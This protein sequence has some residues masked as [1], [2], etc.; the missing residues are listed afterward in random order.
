MSINYD[1]Q[2]IRLSEIIEKSTHNAT[3]LIPDL[4]RPYV[5]SP[6][7]VILLVDSLFRGWPFGSL[8]LWEVAPECYGNNEGIPHRPFWEAVD[9]TDLGNAAVAGQ[10]D[11]PATYYM[12]LDGQQRIQ[13]LLLALGGDN[14]GFCLYDHDWSMSLYERRMRRGRHWSKGTLCVDLEAFQNL[15]KTTRVRK[16]DVQNILEWVR[17]DPE[18][19]TSSYRKPANY[20]TPLKSSYENPGKFI[21]L[22][23]LWDLAQQKLSESEYRDILE[24]FLNNHQLTQEKI[25]DLI[26]PLAEFMAII[27]NVKET[28]FVDCLQI[29]SF[30]ETQQWKKEDYDDAIVNIFTRLNTAGRTLTR[31]E[32]TLAWLKVGW[33]PSLTNNLT[34]GECMNSLKEEI[35]LTGIDL[36]MDDTVRFL[37]LLWAI[38]NRNGVLLDSKDLLKGDIIR[39]MASYIAGNWEV[40]FSGTKT[41]AEFIV[42]RNL[43]ENVGSFNSLFIYWAWSYLSKK[44]LSEH[45]SLRTLEKHSFEV[46]TIKLSE[47]FID[48][49]VI[50]S[51]WA[52]VWAVGAV[53][54]FANYATRLGKTA[55]T[56]KNQNN[57]E[58]ALATLNDTLQFLLGDI[59]KN[60]VSYIETM[61]VTERNKVHLYRLP[62]WIWHRLDCDRWKYSS[63]PM[64]TKGKRTSSLD[65]DHAV[66]DALWKRIIDE[67]EANWEKQRQQG[68][69]PT[70]FIPKGFESKEE[71]LAFINSLGNCT[72]LEKSF[73]ISKSDTPMW[74][75]LSQVHEF[76]RDEITRDEWESAMLLKHDLTEPKDFSLICEGIRER[77]KKMKEELIT[78][79]NGNLTREDI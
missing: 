66:A 36:S 51:Q 21:R 48:R 39:T 78:F 79:I 15:L 44:W 18:K 47:N 69:E 77:E 27:Q 65:V 71:A 58:D 46:E 3:Y 28:S 10:M 57:K 23:R 26:N 75:F 31:E 37:S 30:R 64:R 62:L 53:K 6:R 52:N 63:I 1:S 33:D 68:I 5:W 24:P 25:E 16:I 19:G 12:V 76:E 59:T 8:L 43:I 74:K 14:W 72:L 2:R 22:S 42:S 73:N 70:T 49:W 13:S 4:Q 32:I 45:S 40:I 20:E 56:L 54:N 38:E 50:C 61:M 11:Q 9:K 34:A 7:Q 35:S 67:E 29:K 55:E 17:T 41:G 60:A